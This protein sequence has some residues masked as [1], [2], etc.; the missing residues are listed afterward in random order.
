VQV[1]YPTEIT[2]SNEELLTWKPGPGDVTFPLKRSE[3]R[4]FLDA[5]KSRQP[6]MYDAEAG[7]RNASLSHL[8]LAAID[9]GRK[10]RWDPVAEK[11]IGDREANKH[12]RP[13]PQRAPW[14][15]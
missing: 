7:H 8:A 13:K 10:L 6:P 9:L 11:V 4:D 1:V 5:V 14:R 12:L 3:K 2:A 15:S